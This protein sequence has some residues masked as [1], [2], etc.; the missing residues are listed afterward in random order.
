LDAIIPLKQ[1]NSW[2]KVFYVLVEPPLLGDHHVEIEGK[3]IKGDHLP[4]CEF[5]KRFL[6]EKI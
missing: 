5:A 4:G 2:W 3:A 1:H 6:N